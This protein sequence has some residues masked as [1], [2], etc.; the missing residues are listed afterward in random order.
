MLYKKR[1]DSAITIY[2]EY[3]RLIIISVLLLLLIFAT[4]Y[5]VSI[6]NSGTLIITFLDIGQGDAIFIETPSHKQMIIDG[7]P[8]NAIARALPPHISFFD[9]RIDVMLATHPD[10]DHVTGL[11]SLLKKYQ[12]RSIVKSP[13]KSKTGVFESL[14]QG[15]E[16]EVADRGA[17]KYIGNKGDSIDF[18]D[19][20]TF[21]IV[22]PETN[23][24]HGEETN[25]ESV[26]GLLSYGEHSFLLTG[27]LPSTYEEKI[28]RSDTLPRNITVLK[29][30]H[31]GS[32]YSSSDMFLNYTKPK[33]TIIS[34]GKE[35]KYGHPSKEVLDRLQKISTHII[36]TIDYGSIT[37]ISDGRNLEIKTEK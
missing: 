3:Q 18:G 19:G 36:S 9:T 16:K 37:F 20:V 11:V 24:W 14:E 17:Q 35:N 15:I 25:D 21:R 34:A 26:V 1:I 12:V 33:Y 27:D 5:Y 32:K 28:I 30:G 13:A 31:H 6:R 22:S 2:K 8:G 29:A 7:G 10:A 4:Q 23:I